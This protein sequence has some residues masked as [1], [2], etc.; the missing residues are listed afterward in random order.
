MLTNHHTQEFI[1]HGT[2]IRFLQWYQLYNSTKTIDAYH[3][4][5]VFFLKQLGYEIDVNF[6]SQLIWYY[7]WSIYPTYLMGVRFKILPCIAYLA[8]FLNAVGNSWPVKLLQYHLLYLYLAETTIFIMIL[9]NYSLVRLCGVY[10]SPLYVRK[11]PR[12]FIST[13]QS[14]CLPNVL[15]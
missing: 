3:H 4:H 8:V 10:N 1:S 7:Q 5:Y 11:S 15:G 14:A 6:L 2:W 9:L 12:L 13:L